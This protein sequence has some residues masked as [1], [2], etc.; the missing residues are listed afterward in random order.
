MQ[1]TAAQYRM[2]ETRFRR[3]M[4][5]LRGMCPR[6]RMCPSRATTSSS[7]GPPSRRPP[8]RIA[9]ERGLGK[10][11]PPFRIRSS[12]ILQSSKQRTW[13]MMYRLRHPPPLKGL[14]GPPQQSLRRS[15]SPLPRSDP[16]N[17][18]PHLLFLTR[19]QS[20]RVGH[21]HHFLPSSTVAPHR[22]PMQKREEVRTRC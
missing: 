16:A 22:H 20:R 2:I 10:S 4:R 6:R 1:R 5:L 14:P 11:G 17:L 3:G 15:N 12:D 9:V 7:C 19:I 18:G 13:R 21:L 8:S